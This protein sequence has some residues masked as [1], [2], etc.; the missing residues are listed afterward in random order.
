MEK[1]KSCPGSLIWK[2]VISRGSIGSG[3]E[4]DRI[5]PVFI[6]NGIGSGFYGKPV[7]FAKC[8]A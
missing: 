5:N 6:G 7:G 2:V 8:F 3:F 1:K 4:N